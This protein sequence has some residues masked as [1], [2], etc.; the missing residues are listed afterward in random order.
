MK[1]V[2]GG[3]AEDRAKAKGGGEN[4]KSFWRTPSMRWVVERFACGV[5]WGGVLGVLYRD[6]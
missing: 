2:K 4:R 5:G 6:A 3:K 1:L